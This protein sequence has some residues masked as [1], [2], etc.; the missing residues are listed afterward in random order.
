[1][2]VTWTEKKELFKRVTLTDRPTASLGAVVLAS[3][4]PLYRAR[5][6]DDRTAIKGADGRI[7]VSGEVRR[8]VFDFSGPEA[9]KR[10]TNPMGN[11]NKEGL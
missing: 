7:I 2:F 3:F 4:M 11:H 1:M 10:Q 6:Y 5:I 9:I 8:D